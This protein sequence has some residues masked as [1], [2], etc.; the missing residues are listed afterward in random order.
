MFYSLLES[1]PLGP[2]HSSQTIILWIV[3]LCSQFKNLHEALLRKLFLYC[4]LD[5]NWE[6]R[7]SR[8]TASL[9]LCKVTKDGLGSHV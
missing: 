9:F 8:S 2:E 1:L 4:S 6:R 7:E 5:Y 3:Q